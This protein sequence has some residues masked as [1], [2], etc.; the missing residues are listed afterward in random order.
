[1]H[2]APSARRRRRRTADGYFAGDVSGVG[3]EAFCTGLSAMDSV[4][5][6]ARPATRLVYVSLIDAEPAA[7]RATWPTTLAWS[8]RPKTCALAQQVAKKV[9]R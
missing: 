2:P 4:G 8:P 7:G 9:L 1:M 3:D 5:V 6:L